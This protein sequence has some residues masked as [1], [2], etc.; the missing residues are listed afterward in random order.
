MRNGYPGG[1]YEPPNLT[2]A[3]GSPLPLLNGLTEEQAAILSKYDPKQVIDARRFDT[4]YAVA[5][6]AVNG[7]DIL[8]FAQQVGQQDTLI[9][10]PAV[11]FTKNRMNTNMVQSGQ[12]ERGTT[13]IVTSIQAQVSFP[14]NLDSSLQ[15]SGNTTLPNVTGTAVGADTNKAGILAG[16]LW[17]AICKGGYIEFIV[18]PNKFENGTLDMFPSEFG[19]SGYNAAVQAG[20]SVATSIPVIDGVTNNGFGFARQMLFPRTI[21]PGQNFSVKLNFYNNFTPS[22]NF[23]IKIILAGLELRDI[24]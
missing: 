22:R 15:A 3:D 7:G 20:T 10:N 16:D 6:T 4:K 2:F 17:N 13:L 1:F 14:N 23:D 11:S 19:A 12:L 8:F 18:G 9:N 24:A 21:L 5:G